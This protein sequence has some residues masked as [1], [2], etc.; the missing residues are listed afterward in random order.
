MTATQHALIPTTLGRLAT[1]L[2]PGPEDR[3]PLVLTHGIY[4][5]S[6]L[7]DAVL[8]A[9]DDRTVLTVD[10]P[11]HGSS[12]DP[13]GGWALD[14]HV[15]ALLEVLNHHR[16]DKAV[17]VGH[18]W[19]GMVSLRTALGHPRRVAGLGLVNTPLTR[20]G[21]L[22]R[23]GFRAQQAMLVTAGPVRFYGRKAAASMYDA[24]SLDQRP[25]LAD[26][27]AHRLAR[28]RGRV[29]AQ[30]LESVILQPPD[31]LEQLPRVHVPVIVIA[32]TGDYV[33]PPATQHAVASALPRATV[34]T[35]AGAHISP[36]ED[37]T[38]TAE[39]VRDLLRRA[40]TA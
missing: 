23:V 16:L 1:T 4:M 36:Q 26:D 30:T 17:L 5:D 3:L 2:R 7:W 15:G 14:H 31:M 6:G 37:P 9:L 40:E 22:S 21:A 19:G 10:G 11:G 18:S 13:P 39:A 27:M 34:T 38:A 28:R 29:L 8:P 33:L 25:S 12:E 32:G 35:T 20:P 24:A